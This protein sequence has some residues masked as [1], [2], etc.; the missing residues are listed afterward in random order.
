MKRSIN[1]TIA[2]LLFL[3]FNSYSGYSQSFELL[4]KDT[5]VIY[6][7]DDTT[8][9]AHL[10][11]KNTSM[12]TVKFIVE[13][14]IKEIQDGS[15]YYFCDFNTCWPPM[16]HDK[17]SSGNSL[18]AGATTAKSFYVGF[19]HRGI[20]GKNVF[21]Y[22]VTNI[23]DESDSFDFDITFDIA[24]GIED[25]LQVPLLTAPNPASDFI[26]FSGFEKLSVLGTS[27]YVYDVQGNLVENELN[28][29]SN[30]TLTL[31]T[32]NYQNGTYYYSIVSG[33]SII[34]SGAFVVNK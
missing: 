13:I 14:T 27:L 19:K 29:N 18:A 7:L 33:T 11:F 17:T 23:S 3:V 31:N 21:N 8:I 5:L 9:E 22:K 15:K 16:D 20:S 32:M 24:S 30:P 34:K 25:E 26:V 1:L 4:S 10:E 12:D 6:T 2:A 28:I